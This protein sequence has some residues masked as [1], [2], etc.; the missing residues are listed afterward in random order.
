MNWSFARAARVCLVAA[1][2]HSGGAHA[3][4]AVDSLSLRQVIDA[5]LAGNPELQ[6]FAFRFRA[7]DAR[8]QQAAL[9]PGVEASFELENFAGSGEARGVDAAE[10]TFA[11]SQVIELGGKRDARLAAAA[12]GRTLLD[13]ERQVRQ[14]DVL[15]E[16]TRRFITLAARQEQLKL[17]RSA[18]DLAQRTAAASERRV[19]AA[20][21]P[22]AELDR[23]QIAWDR[24]RLDERRALTEIETA[25][26][27]LAAM[28][29]QSQPLIDGHPFGEVQADLFTMP[30]VG[31]F[32]ELL[33]RLSANPDFLRFA[34]EA[35]LRDAELR[36]AATLG[37]PDMQFSVG[38][39]RF[40]SS[41]DSA[42]VAS[43]SVPLS[44]GRRGQSYVAE[45]RANRELVEA[46]R[47]MAEVKAQATLYELHRELDRAVVEAQTLRN[48]ILPRTQEA[49]KE[50]EYA[51]ERGRY[52]YLEFVDAQR[53]FLSVQ[54]NL[55][56]ASANAHALR[57]EIERLINSSLTSAP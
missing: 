56:E 38:L 50:V 24:A 7:Q 20:K 21:S 10:A 55:I 5:A 12:A 3:A 57:T 35:R 54:A 48:N 6:S 27:Q 51:Y 40:E 11:L 25:R 28:W 44:S 43:F 34:S 2:L 29:G 17:A 52:N 37:K 42:L 9:R 41:G 46:E 8:A 18:V 23:A 32:P 19:N 47:R 45:A 22:H 30:A 14:L 31:E 33:Q 1:A 4:E 39:R 36:L 53:E 16:V 13:A 15:A 26:K 49:L